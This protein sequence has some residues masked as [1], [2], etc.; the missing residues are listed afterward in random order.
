M[1]IVPVAAVAAVFTVRRDGWL[2]GLMIFVPVLVL[3]LPSFLQVLAHQFD[4]ALEIANNL[5]LKRFPHHYDPRTWGF[6]QGSLFAGI[7]VA[8]GIGAVL[9]RPATR[10]VLSRPSRS[11][12]S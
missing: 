10:P 8:G 7:V 4:P 2:R 6:V 11:W 9:R 3:G 5:T 1:L 12:R